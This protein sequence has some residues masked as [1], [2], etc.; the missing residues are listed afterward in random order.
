MRT[1]KAAPQEEMCPQQ[2]PSVTEKNSVA[3]L[4]WREEKEEGRTTND[5]SWS[6]GTR[7]LCQRRCKDHPVPSIAAGA[8]MF[9]S[10][11]CARRHHTGVPAPAD[12]A[13]PEEVCWWRPTAG[14]QRGHSGREKRGGC[15]WGGWAF[16]AFGLLKSWKDMVF[17]RYYHNFT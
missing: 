10:A 15:V 14:L 1:C 9:N 6:V 13:A 2:T 17:Q 3:A 8:S 12:R 5:F 11:R 4:G 16:S 7:W